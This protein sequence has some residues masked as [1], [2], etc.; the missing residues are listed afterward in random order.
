MPTFTMLAGERIGN[1]SEAGHDDGRHRSGMLEGAR[2]P[3]EGGVT[4]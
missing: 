1:W 3:H 2:V 4:G